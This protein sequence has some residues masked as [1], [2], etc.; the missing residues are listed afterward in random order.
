MDEVAQD[1]ECQADYADA[2]GDDCGLDV[3]VVV[4][5]EIQQRI[6]PAIGLG[7]AFDDLDVGFWLI[8]ETWNL[9]AVVD[10][11]VHGIEYLAYR[12]P[13]FLIVSVT[14]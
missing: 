4:I 10:F 12:L 14:I 9:F 1:D 3:I 7:C 11:V 13:F 5:K 8:A 2:D 6:T